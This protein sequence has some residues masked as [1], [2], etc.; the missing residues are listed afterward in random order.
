M[1]IFFSVFFG[2]IGLCFVL[3]GC[4]SETATIMQQTYFEIQT[5][6]GIITLALSA[7]IAVLSSLSSQS[8]KSLYESQ[9]IERQLKIIAA[10]ES[11][12]EAILQ[13]M[14]AAAEAARTE[15]N[16]WNERTDELLQA[17]E[18]NTRESK[19]S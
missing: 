4:V 19:E 16:Q 17:I 9:E 12:L 2:L 11:A 1:A 8:Q 14:V 7:M 5:I 15:A 3:N 10:K 13:R 18:K 6:G